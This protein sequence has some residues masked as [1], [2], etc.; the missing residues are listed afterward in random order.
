MYRYFNIFSKIDSVHTFIVTF[1]ML[2]LSKFTC[3]LSFV[4]STVLARYSYCPVF[5]VLGAITESSG[6]L[7]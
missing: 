3:A 4:F 5:P 6:A 2:S 7:N 1:D